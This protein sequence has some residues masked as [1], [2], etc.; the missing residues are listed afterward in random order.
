MKKR[1]ISLLLTIVLVLGLIPPMRA[2]AL[3]YEL[4][5]AVI[6]NNVGLDDGYYVLEGS[7][8]AKKG[9]SPRKC[10]LVPLGTP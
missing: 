5:D 4:A 3:T 10:R 2:N 6:V 8:E 9:A 1:L 7:T